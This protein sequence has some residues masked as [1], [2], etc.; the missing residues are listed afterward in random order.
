MSQLPLL[1]SDSSGP[2]V[3][4]IVL[5]AKRSLGVAYCWYST[6]MHQCGSVA[7]QMKVDHWMTSLSQMV[8]Q[9][10]LREV[11]SETGESPQGSPEG[12]RRNWSA[13][14]CPCR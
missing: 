11:R 8:G 12:L 5:C 13:V 6:V 2:L 10:E 3:I 4:D 1:I 9:D 7:D 14:N